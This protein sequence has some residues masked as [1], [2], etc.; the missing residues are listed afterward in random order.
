MPDAHN[1][2]ARVTGYPTEKNHELLRRIISASSNRGGLVL[3][4]FSGSGA[5]L[6]AASELGRAWIGIDNSTHAIATTLE[7]F[8]R[9]PQLMGDY[10]ARLRRE[11]DALPLLTGLEPPDP[12]PEAPRTAPAPAIRDF[13][14]HHTGP[15]DAELAAALRDWERYRQRRAT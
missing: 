8:R 13:T 6:H 7:R 4:C 9:G 10:V 12:P 3:D 2:N 15:I 14:I 1:Q 11:E 5:T